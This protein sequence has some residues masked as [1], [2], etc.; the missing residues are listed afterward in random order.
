MHHVRSAASGEC[1][2]VR[3]PGHE[4]VRVTVAWRSCNDHTN[5][6]IARLLRSGA[7][8]AVRQGPAKFTAVEVALNGA[9][10]ALLRNAIVQVEALE[11]LL[12]LRFGNPSSPHLGHSMLL[13]SH[14]ESRQA[15]RGFR[16]NGP[17]GVGC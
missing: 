2:L 15:M 11:E 10:L 16:P 1:L 12:L 17:A 4:A 6:V 3:L 13:A 7:A 9:Q 8:L 5:I 14:V